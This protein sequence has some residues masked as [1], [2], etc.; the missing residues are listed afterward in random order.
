MEYPI[1]A[2]SW[3]LISWQAGSWKYAAGPLSMFLDR[4]L[5]ILA[6]GPFIAES[7]FYL[8]WCEL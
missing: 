4:Q 7:D 6:S 8:L 5:Q 2:D 1:H 3:K